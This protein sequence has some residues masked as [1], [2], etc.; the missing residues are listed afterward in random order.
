MANDFPSSI[1][2]QKRWKLSM[3]ATTSHCPTTGPKS[4]IDAVAENLRLPRV[5]FSA[6]RQHRSRVDSAQH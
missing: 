6:T 1:L 4:K 5:T 3:V 2:T